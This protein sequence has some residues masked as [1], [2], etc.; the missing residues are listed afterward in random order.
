MAALRAFT[1]D[2][3]SEW[4][5]PGKG[6]VVAELLAPGSDASRTSKEL[7]PL[8]FSFDREIAVGILDLGAVFNDAPAP[9]FQEDPTLV[10]FHHGRPV[11]W[12]SGEE[13]F[14]KMDAWLSMVRTWSPDFFDSHPT[15]A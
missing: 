7:L 10:L 12:F 3:W 8:A 6:L 2:N 15:G 5:R 4:S 11:R 14:Q 1:A 13:R 9:W